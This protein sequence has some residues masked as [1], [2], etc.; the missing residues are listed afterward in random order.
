MKKKILFIIL[1]IIMSVI[2]VVGTI[3]SVQ[4]YKEMVSVASFSLPL[5]LVFAGWIVFTFAAFIGAFIFLVNILKYSGK[6]RD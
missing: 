4:A 5:V 2:A 1:T 3:L 6:G